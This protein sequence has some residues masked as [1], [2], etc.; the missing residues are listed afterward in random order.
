MSQVIHKICELVLK[1]DAVIAMEDLNG[2]FMNSRIKIEKQVYRK[3]EKMLT[4]K[5]NYLVD[6]KADPM[7]DG[8]LLRAYQLTNMPDGKGRG[9]QDGILFYIPAWCTS[10]IDPTTG[11]VDLLRPKNYRTME[12]AKDFFGRFQK[13]CFQEEEDLFAFHFRYS[14]FPNGSTAGDTE[15]TVCTNDSRIRTFRNPEKN[16][17][18]D[19]EKVVL[20]DKF[21]AL[22]QEYGIPCN[23][24]MKAAILAQNSF[25]FYKRLCEL[26]ALTLQMRNSISGRTDG[27]YHFSGKKR[28]RSVLRQ[29]N[30]HVRLASRCGR[31]RCLQYREKGTALYP[32]TERTGCGAADEGEHQQHEGGMA[33]ICTELP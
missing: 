1:Y 19:Y 4:D 16:N 20:T 30:R 31:E 7:A 3:F 27:L 12:A 21:K 22:F 26:L 32:E 2:G 9:L 13:I 23:S 14:D 11:F 6:K 8:G 18:W 29:Q 25:Q 24:D 33:H 28:F 5:L 17:E 15:W 10:K